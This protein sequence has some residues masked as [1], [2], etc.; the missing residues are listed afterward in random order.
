[1]NISAYIRLFRIEH[2]VLLS[3][4]VL[5]SEIFAC[6][7]AGIPLPAISM[8]LISMAVPFLIEMGSFALNDYVDQKADIENKRTDRPL[9]NRE[10]ESTEALAAA[11]FCY[12]AGIFIAVS[13]P[14][15][16]FA[17]AAVFAVLSVAYNYRLKDLPLAGN[18][19]IAASMAI[20]FLFGSLIATGIVYP[21]IALIASVAF[22]AGLG[23]EIV[24]SAEDL[25][26][27]V[28]HRK[29]RTL[30]AVIGKKNACLL[31]AAL[32]LSLVPLSFLPFFY[33]LRPNILSLGL[34][35]VTAA[36][37]VAQAWSVASSQE[38]GNLKS[39]R[40][41]SLL[42]LGIGLAGYAASLL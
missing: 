8:L 11:G 20:P 23:R 12:I 5:L 9:V 37:F 25:E 6:F 16:A 24:K 30:P 4:A 35:A 40:K 27:D 17:I 39:A 22:V 15:E 26:G 13:L 7:A 29:S 18:L 14:F 19:Y 42:S 10:L 28:K 41:A 36:A 3:S 2:A 33:G 34:V 31:S 1:M 32:Y 38:K 21:H